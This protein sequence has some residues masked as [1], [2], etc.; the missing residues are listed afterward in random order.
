MCGVKGVE[1][2]SMQNYHDFTQDNTKN[3]TQNTPTTTV[4]GA[5]CGR[6]LIAMEK[7]KVS[8]GMSEKGEKVWAQ[9]LKP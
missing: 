2:T 9:P 3:Q 6:E 4:G 5:N 7:E 1:N 8:T